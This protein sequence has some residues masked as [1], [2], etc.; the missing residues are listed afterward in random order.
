MASKPTK[1]TTNSGIDSLS[2]FRKLSDFEETD[3]ISTGIRNL[4]KILAG[5]VPKNSILEAFG[6]EQGGKS[7]I[8]LQLAGEAQKHGEV[9]YYD[10]ENCF[11]RSKAANSNVDA[12]RIY[13]GDISSGENMFS[14]IEEVMGCGGVSLIIV[15]SVAA[16]MT[17]AELAGEPGDS[18]VAALARLLS[19]N[20]KRLSNFQDQHN[21]GTIVFFVNQIRES[22]GGG[23]FAFGPQTYT[24]GGRALKFYSSTRLKVSKREAIRIGS[25]ETSEVIGQKVQV[26]N[27]KTRYA[28]PFQKATFD[29]YYDRDIG[30]SNES[31]ILDEAIKA[32]IVIQGGAWFT[33]VDGTKLGQG[34]QKALETMRNDPEYTNNLL[35][36]L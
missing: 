9:V 6:P 21:P 7:C 19:Y 11:E 26:E 20:V 33:D 23:G 5:G 34:R 2:G 17:E 18:F 10:L 35:L 1:K 24:P 25:A 13:F 14:S 32:K 15:D 27:V 29:L 8:A 4:D 28:P 12:D 31:S 36:Q 16:I 22:I 30:V 3:K